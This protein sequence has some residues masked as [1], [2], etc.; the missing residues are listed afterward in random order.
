MKE[1]TNNIATVVSG[2]LCT[3]CGG[4][5]GCCPFHAIGFR[6]HPKK[7]LL[8]VVDETRC[9]CCGICLQVCP[10]PSVDIPGFQRS[11]FG[12]EPRDVYFG[13][14]IRLLAGYT[15]DN[16]IR[17]NGASGG[18][19]TAM[20]VELLK[21]GEIHGA[22]VVTMNPV[23]PLEPRVFIARTV[24]EIV[25]AQQSKYLPVPMNQGLQEILRSRGERF[26]VVGLPCHFQ[27]LAMAKR[28]F[29][30]LK[31]KIVLGIG[32][33]CGYNPTLSSTRFLIRRAGVKN[34]SSV[35][36]IR[37]RDGDW[38]CGFRVITDDG[39][40]H[41]L[42]PTSHFVFAHWVFERHRCA[43]CNDQLCEFSDLSVG[44]EWKPVPRED[45]LG[46]SYII[47]RTPVGDRWV[48]RLAR[49]G[50]LHVEPTTRAEIYSGNYAT[51]IFKK[52]GNRA[53]FR[54]RKMLG[55]PFPD[56]RVNRNPRLDLRY[57]VGAS[58]I[59]TVSSLFEMDWVSRPGLRIPVRL[60]Q[61]YVHL[62]IK[63]FE[64]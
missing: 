39:Q 23:R 43:M 2:G 24:E 33:F 8:P 60:F 15:T 35:R 56:Y 9:T 50:V 25:S 26:A 37:Y 3:Q 20:L 62:I 27:N 14:T 10:G 40:D 58:L 61:K 53:F 30:I 47:T 11:M 63:L 22:L 45:K 28:V 59:W 17:Y 55:K 1:S 4:C 42:F 38:P 19:V 7:G 16:A 18:V 44:D 41:F 64:K 52:R 54:I 46:W 32:L 49:E 48:S 21:R 34:V 13:N 51:L 5:A 36:E 57:F 6:Q 29:P 12:R 31:E